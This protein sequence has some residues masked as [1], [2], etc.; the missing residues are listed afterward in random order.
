MADEQMV[1]RAKDIDRLRWEFNKVREFQR[2]WPAAYQVTNFH[3]A[4]TALLR[5]SRTPYRV[6]EKKS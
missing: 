3:R 5:N 6:E 2:K 1:V 4:I